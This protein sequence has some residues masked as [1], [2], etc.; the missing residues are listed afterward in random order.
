MKNYIQLLDHTGAPIDSTLITNSL[1]NIQRFKL[2]LSEIK[3]AI[4][5]LNIHEL[6]AYAED[7][8]LTW[9][10]SN[11]ELINTLGFPECIEYFL[12]FREHVYYTWP[13]DALEFLEKNGM[14]STVQIYR[15]ALKSSEANQNFGLS[16]TTL[17]NVADNYAS[18]LRDG[19]VL[20]AKVSMSDILIFISEESEVLVL[21]HKIVKD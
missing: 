13:N 12:T 8:Y 20:N 17:P 1:K 7:F 5:N 19:I 15:G 6:K 2:E 9:Y 10:A 16:W 21:P 14:D 11:T 3:P 4:N 18:R